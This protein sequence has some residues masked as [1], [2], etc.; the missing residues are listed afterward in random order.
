MTSNYLQKDNTLQ[1]TVYLFHFTKKKYTY[2]LLI[3]ID[4]SIFTDL[5]I[6]FTLLVIYLNFIRMPDK[7]IVFFT[8]V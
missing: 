8:L 7:S 5:S 4:L 3:N 6:L 2:T 1:T